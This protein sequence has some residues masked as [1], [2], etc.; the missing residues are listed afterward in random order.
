MCYLAKSELNKCRIKCR[1]VIDN[2]LIHVY[3]YI[4]LQY[5]M[6]TVPS[7]QSYLAFL[8]VKIAIQVAYQRM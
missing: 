5:A 1:A 4:F 2:Y 7:L 8:A 3:T 6:H